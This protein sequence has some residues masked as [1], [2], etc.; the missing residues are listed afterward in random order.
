MA[1]ALMV[2]VAGCSELPA[3]VDGDLTDGWRTPPAAL[4]FRPTAG[5][6]A[7]LVETATIEDDDAVPCTEPHLAETFAVADL[8]EV[9]AAARAARAFQECSARATTFVGGDW[10]TGWLILQPVLPSDKAWAGGARWVRCDVAETAPSDGTL[11]RRT[12]SVRGGLAGAGKLKMTC[13]NATVAGDQVTG[14]RAMS[15]AQK[16]TSEFAGLFVSKRA[17][18]SAITAAEMEKG[19]NAAI[20]KF[21]GIP[22]DSTIKNRVGWLG[23]PPDKDSWRLGD[24]AVRC[25]LWLNGE[26]MTGTYRNA[27]TKKLKIH[28]VYR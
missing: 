11:V 16:H 14:L 6:H 25:F 10:R 21:A 8:G 23:F 28:Y 9:T 26:P 2:A 5:C 4:Q 20:A 24:R 17:T 13:A 15:C 12:G 1:G 7:D 27:G 19:C 3:G 22:N 18:S